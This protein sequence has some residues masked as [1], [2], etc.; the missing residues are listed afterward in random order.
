MKQEPVAP[1]SHAVV[2]QSPPDKQRPRIRLSRNGPYLVTVDDLTNSK[3]ERLQ[4]WNGVALCR[5]G[6]SHRKPF[7]D[8]SHIRIGFSDDPR[9]DR[10]PC[11]VVDDRGAAQPGSSD[12][13][14]PSI[15]IARNGPYE[16]QG[17]DLDTDNW[18]EGASRERYSLCRCGGSKNKPFCDGTHRS[19]NFQDDNN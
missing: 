6:A 18:S 16:V 14:A 12:L 11:G 15:R 2:G 4:G 13:T 17:F 10:T 8:S 1:F 7:C 9:P 3:G 5:C 19:I